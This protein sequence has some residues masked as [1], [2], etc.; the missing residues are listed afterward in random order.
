[1]EIAEI[2]KKCDSWSPVVHDR[3]GDGR[4]YVEVRFDKK[5]DAQ[6]FAVELMMITSGQYD[7]AT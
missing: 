3:Q 4:Y 1:M 2:I 6:A 7:E 5:E